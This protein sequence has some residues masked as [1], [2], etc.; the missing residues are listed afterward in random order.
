MSDPTAHF[1]EL[2]SVV[3]RFA[4]DS[5]DG[6]QL[7]GTQFTT[8]SAVFGNDISTLPD[9][10]A[11]IRA[12]AGTLAGVSG[13]Q[14]NLSQH[15]IL[16]PGDAPF[17]LVAMNPAALKASLPDLEIGGIIIVNTDAF[18]PTNLKKADYESNPLEDGSLK[19][20][21]VHEVPLT[22]LTREALKGLETLS[23]KEKDRCQNF[24][25]LG[26]TFWIFDRSL[27][28]S[29][30]WIENKFAKKPEIAQANKIALETG[31]F[32]GET[33]EVFRRRFH[34]RPASLPAGTYRNVTGNEAMALGL[35]TAAQKMDKPLFYGSYP[36]T[37]ASDILHALAPLRNFDV[38]TFQAED[39]IAAMGSVIGA[40]FGGALAVTGTSGPGL[41]LKSEAMNLAIM[42]EL[43]MVIVNVQRG[44]PSTGL[45]TKTEQADLLQALYGR[46]GES[47]I[48]VLAPKGPSDCFDIAY[49]A[50]R[51][52]VRAMT[53]VLVLSEGYLANSSEPWLIPDPNDIEP[54][55]VK[56]PEGRSEDDAPFFPYLRDEETLGRPWAIPGTPGLEHRIGG[57][58]KAPI[59][60]NVSQ[61]PRH[62]EQMIKLRAEKVARLANAVPEQDVFGPAEGDLLV[63]TW[64]GTF[65]A[66]RTA[67]TRA[68]KNH[69]YDVAHAHLRFLNP[70]PRNME[71]ILRSYK[72]I[73]VPELN[74]GQLAFVLRGTYGLDNII[75]YPKL[76]ARPFKIGEVYQKLEELFNN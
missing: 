62:H 64:G 27:D 9:Y 37:P 4:G 48:P 12:P 15:D 60:G 42:L 13:F 3:I 5:G 46:N 58:A 68:R 44:G 66:V 35:V 34:I 1:E 19:S 16:T 29:E 61:D 69:N 65:G 40:A 33:T 51:L 38:R 30:S 23:T 26:M 76:H 18:T 75:S 28:T 71:K 55:V 67:V 22:S 20:Y 36:I 41:A 53:P 63:I 17:V 31:F 56:H 24:F 49:E 11:E 47:P 8:T 45:P 72:R 6:M 25:A 10:P 43:P 21:E 52:A 39:E 7:T 70:F 50:C 54:I 74:N 2:E 73:L 32:F 57:L 14:V 59:T